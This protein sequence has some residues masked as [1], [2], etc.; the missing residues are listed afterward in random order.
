M[1]LIRGSRPTSVVTRLP[2][3]ALAGQPCCPTDI[4]LDSPITCSCGCVSR[5]AST[6]RPG[7]LPFFADWA[8]WCGLKI[9]PLL[10]PTTE[11]KQSSTRFIT[12]AGIQVQ[13]T[14]IPLWSNSKSGFYLVMNGIFV[15]EP[16]SMGTIL[17][18]RTLCVYC[19][20]FNNTHT[21]ICQ[22]KEK[23]INISAHEI[24]L[25]LYKIEDS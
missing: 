17:H 24:F 12:L 11:K 10:L 18:C 3:R 25:V 14:L 8:N 21:A 5:I 6:R 2:L 7:A 13:L 1:Q 16:S 4:S 23:I 20:H 22:V 9:Q 19:H 15:K